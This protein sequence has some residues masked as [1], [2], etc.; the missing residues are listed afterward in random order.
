VG[1]KGGMS[2]FPQRPTRLSDNAISSPPLDEKFRVSPQLTTRR[3]E[4]MRKVNECSR[5]ELLRL[6]FDLPTQVLRRALHKDIHDCIPSDA[7]LWSKRFDEALFGSVSS[8]LFSGNKT[9][10]GIEP[11]KEPTIMNLS[12]PLMHKI[13]QYLDTG[14]VWFGTVSVSR[15]FRQISF[16]PR[17]WRVVS[18]PRFEVFSRSWLPHDFAVPCG[19]TVP[20]LRRWI[21]AWSKVEKFGM[22][23]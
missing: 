14:T 12:E 23:S 7:H 4:L 18:F 19:V 1:K 11:S 6:Y 20:F 9:P 3:L 22:Q 10:F 21:S 16:D 2:Y 5:E 15:K 13:F 8:D 17:S